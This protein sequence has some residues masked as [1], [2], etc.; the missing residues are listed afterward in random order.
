MEQLFEFI[1]N[2]PLLTGAFGIV[3]AILVFTEITRLTRKFSEVSTR[4]AIDLINRRD[5]VVIDVSSSSDFGKGHISGARHFTPT[6]IES[7]N[8]KLMK[9]ADRPVV[10]C[11]KNGQVSPQ[12]AGKLTKMGFGEVYV[13]KGGLAQWRADQQPITR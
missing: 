8:Q 4:Q 7:G 12:M 10:V 11:C 1:G 3:A 2:H 9:F 6:Q 5:A 13:L